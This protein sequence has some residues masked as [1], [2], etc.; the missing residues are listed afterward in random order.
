MTHEQALQAATNAAANAGQAWRLPNT[1]EIMTIANL[2]LSVPVI[3]DILSF[4][5]DLN[6]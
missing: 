6:P 3:V 5:R 1:K 4:G 2:G